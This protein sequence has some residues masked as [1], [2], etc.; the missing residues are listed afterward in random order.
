MAHGRRIR[1]LSQDVLNYPARSDTSKAPESQVDTTHDALPKK[2][3]HE[4]HHLGQAACGP[5]QSMRATGPTLTMRAYTTHVQRLNDHAHHTLTCTGQVLYLER[6]TGLRIRLKSLW[7]RL[8]VS[9][10]RPHVLCNYATDSIYDHL[11]LSL[12]PSHQRPG[13]KVGVRMHTPRPVG[14]QVNKVGVKA[15]RV[16][17]LGV[18]NLGVTTT[19]LGPSAI[20]STISCTLTSS[21]NTARSS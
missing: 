3:A 11:I 14:M 6:Y 4:I 16:S 20:P 8:N 19:R 5:T 7:T 2:A 10:K 15:M 17:N 12:K 1:I 9:V 18:N 21:T 13:F